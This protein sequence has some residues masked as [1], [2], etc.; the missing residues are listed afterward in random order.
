MENPT[1][2]YDLD[3]PPVPYIARRNVGEEWKPEF[4]DRHLPQAGFITDFVYATRGIESPTNFC[5]WTAVFLLSSLLKRDAWLKWFPGVLFPNLYILFV[6]PPRICPKSTPIILCEKYIYKKMFTHF[7]DPLQRKGKELNIVHSRATMEALYKELVPKIESVNIIGPSGQFETRQLDMGSKL[8]IMASEFSTFLGRAQYSIGLVDKLTDWYDCKDE[9]DSFTISGGEVQLKDLYVTILGGTTFDGLK[10]SIPPEALKGGF[11]SRLIIVLNRKE[12][13]RFAFPIEIPGAPSF[14]E[15]SKRLA[16]I[17]ENAQ[18]EFTFS[19][20][21][22]QR[23]KEWYDEFKDKLAEGY[24]GEMDRSRMDT[25]VL[26]LSVV[27]HVQRYTTDREITIDDFNDAVQMIES[28]AD[29]EE[30]PLEDVGTTVYERIYG[31]VLKKFQKLESGDKLSFRK[32]LRDVSPEK[33]GGNTLHIKEAINQLWSEG[34]VRA[35]NGPTMINHRLSFASN[36][37]YEWMGN[38]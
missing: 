36:E 13:R 33:K 37:E 14:D 7:N 38:E 16:W 29:P 31:S 34:R 32:I 5:A 4:W 15:L 9:D 6:A 23:Y 30:N 20:K 27:M 19:P 24:Y 11:I 3:H 21:A 10:L 22:T 28:S 2:N 1:T 18:G 12:T 8:C 17:V 35:Y 26:K 25:N